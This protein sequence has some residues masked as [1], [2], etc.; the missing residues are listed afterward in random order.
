MQHKTFFLSIETLN[1][2]SILLQKKC[3]TNDGFDLNLRS[4]LEK[5]HALRSSKKAYC[6][7][8]CLIEKRCLDK[9]NIETICIKHKEK[10]KV[11]LEIFIV[12]SYVTL[13]AQTRKRFPIFSCV[14]KVFLISTNP[15]GLG[16]SMLKIWIFLFYSVFSIE[17]PG[18]NTGT[19]TFLLKAEKWYLNVLLFLLCQ[20][21]AKE[22][23]EFLSNTVKKFVGKHFTLQKQTIHICIA[24]KIIFF[25]SL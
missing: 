2:K 23:I 16:V 18:N 9:Y 6:G 7:S 5:T 3:F 25:R 10:T 20:P 24:T 19:T 1:A 12:K 14:F 17:L 11:K 4:T 21:N 15:P 13:W 22:V 8:N